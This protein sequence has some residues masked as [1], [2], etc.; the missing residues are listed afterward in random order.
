MSQRR[1]C[2]VLFVRE[3]GH[4]VAA[5]WSKMPELLLEPFRVPLK[6][7]HQPVVCGYKHRYHIE[8][9]LPELHSA[10]ALVRRAH[11]YDPVRRRLNRPMFF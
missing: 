6:V 11:E 7:L 5:D 4:K 9:Q 3:L 10:A 2:L 1:R 8:Q